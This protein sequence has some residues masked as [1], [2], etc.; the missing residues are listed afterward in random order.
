[1]SAGVARAVERQQA[2]ADLARARAEFIAGAAVGL[3]AAEH[4]FGVAVDRARVRGPEPADF[5][6]DD[7]RLLVGPAPLERRRRRRPVEARAGCGRS[8]SS[9]CGRRGRRPP[10]SAAAR[11]PAARAPAPA[12]RRCA[13]W[14]ASMPRLVAPSSS[15]SQRTSV[16]L[17]P[18][19]DAP[20]S[21]PSGD[22]HT[23]RR[24][25]AAPAT[26]SVSVRRSKRTPAGVGQVLAG[27]EVAA[28][29]GDVRPVAVAVGQA[30]GD[31]A[32]RSRDHRRQARH[33]HAVEVEV[34]RRAA[35]RGTR[36][37]ARAASGACRWRPAPR[38]W[39]YGRRP[40]PSCCCPGA[41]A[42]NAPGARGRRRRCRGDPVARRSSSSGG[43]TGGDSTP[44]ARRLRR[45]GGGREVRRIPFRAA[46]EQELQH[47]RAPGPNRP[48]PPR[49]P[50]R[51]SRRARRARAAA[52]RAGCRRTAAATTSHA[53]PAASLPRATAPAARAAPSTPRAASAAS[54]ARR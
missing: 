28:D 38:R 22:D 41:G 21:T 24:C 54:R 32:V 43:G 50:R 46:R 3:V 29:L 9:R 36:P 26:S 25:G 52:A 14:N 44:L 16:Q 34:R 6:I 40:P 33:R 17:R 8:P 39:P 42:R 20:S 10:G 47:A 35:G 12:R 51:S 48:R 5:R 53:A 11:R 18:S 23:S 19:A 2:V 37:S 13:D 15:A 4:A 7:A 49:P 27:G 31:P 30:P 1:M 45:L